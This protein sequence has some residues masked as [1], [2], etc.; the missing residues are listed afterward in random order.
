MPRSGKVVQDLSLLLVQF[1]DLAYSAGAKLFSIPDDCSCSYGDSGNGM[2][3]GRSLRGEE[4][5]SKTS[6]DR[7][8]SFGIVG[9]STPNITIWRTN[10]K[11]CS[12]LC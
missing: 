1:Y 6:R 4:R 9:S 10:R 5:I 12:S 2:S 11:P 3:S 7:E 8:K